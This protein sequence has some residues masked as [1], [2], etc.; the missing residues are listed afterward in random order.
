MLE[1]FLT[2]VFAVSSV[3]ALFLSALRY[4]LE[5][6]KDNAWET[7]VRLMASDPDSRVRSDDFADLY[8]A[9]RYLEKH[10]DC[11]D[12]AWSLSEA[13]RSRKLQAQQADTGDAADQ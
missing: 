6:N 12:D 5:R 11:L 7:T 2:A 4:R 9:L 10:P 1:L 8:T 13:M 3:G